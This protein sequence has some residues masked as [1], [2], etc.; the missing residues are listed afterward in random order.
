VYPLQTLQQKEQ[1]QADTSV[2]TTNVAAADSRLAPGT[3]H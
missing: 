2:C 1:C 3:A